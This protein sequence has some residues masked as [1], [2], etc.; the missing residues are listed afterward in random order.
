MRPAA[1]PSPYSC[2]RVGREPRGRDARAERVRVVVDEHVRAGG[3]GVDPLGGRPQR[4]AGHAEP[5]RLLLQAARVGDDRRAPATSAASRG[6]RAARS[7]RDVAQLDRLVEQRGACAGA[8]GRRTAVDAVDSPSTIARSRSGSVT[9]ASRWIVSDD[10]AA[11]L[12]AEPLER[13]RAFARDRREERGSRRPSRRR[14][15]RAGRRRLRARAAP[16]S[17]R[18]GRRAARRAGRPRSGC[19]PPASTRSKL[20]SPAS[21]CATGTSPRGARAGERRVRV[22]VDEHPVGP[23]AAST[24]SRDRRGHRRRVGGAQVEPVAR[25]RRSSSSSK[26]TC[27]SSASQCWPVCSDDLVDPARRGARA[28]AAPT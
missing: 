23:L 28:R 1:W 8:P 11:G 21:T 3:D 5:V 2:G 4:H 16:P 13:R 6:S 25:A 17:A 7:A 18:R 20:R 9:F 26:K 12:D 10:V 27:D 14:R 24:T 15:P 22:A 19:A